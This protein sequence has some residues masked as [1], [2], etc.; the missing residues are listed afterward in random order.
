M[1]HGVRVA[2]CCNC[3]TALLDLQSDLSSCYAVCGAHLLAE[4][5]RISCNTHKDGADLLAEML[6]ISCNTHKGG[7]QLLA[8][9]FRIFCKTHLTTALAKPV[10]HPRVQQ[11]APRVGR[12]LS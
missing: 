3:V 12:A 6:R 9:M 1:L 4:M 5:L 2:M 10:C 7:A 11:S 8:D